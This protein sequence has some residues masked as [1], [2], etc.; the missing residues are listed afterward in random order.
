MA[1]HVSMDFAA[2]LMLSKVHTNQQMLSSGN[3]PCV[4]RMPRG[5]RLLGVTSLVEA[6]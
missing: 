5:G 6:T 1:V 2:R 3:R 4:D